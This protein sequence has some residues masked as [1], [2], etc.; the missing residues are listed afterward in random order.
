MSHSRDSLTIIYNGPSM[1]PTLRPLDVLHVVPY[2][3]GEIR[4]GDVVVF[5]PPGS[6]HKV[7]HRVLSVAPRGV[8][9]RGDNSLVTD[10][11]VL[12]PD[13]IL[14]R[15]TY[16]SRGRKRFTV[17]GGTA[18]TLRALGARCLLVMRV[19]LYSLVRPVYHLLARS[20]VVRRLVP[21]GSKT[22][23]VCFKRASGEE[24]QLLWGDRVIATRCCDAGRWNIRP[25]FRLFIDER[26]LPGRGVPPP[27]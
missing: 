5:C 27:E 2:D 3:G 25:P 24:L 20:G 9:T 22:R 7:A 19:G 26:T 6:S 11:W 12:G 4:R 14:G 1:N 23:V 18:G 16:A 15:V 13:D 17:H 8:T 10:T 21:I